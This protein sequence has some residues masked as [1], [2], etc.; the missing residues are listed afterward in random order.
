M[1]PSHSQFSRAVQ[2]LLVKKI[3]YEHAKRRI[4]DQYIERRK[5][6]IERHGKMQHQSLESAAEFANQRAEFWMT[7]V[8]REIEDDIDQV[9]DDFT[10]SVKSDLNDAVQE[11]K[12]EGVR[13]SKKM[14]TG[15]AFDDSPDFLKSFD[16]FKAIDGSESE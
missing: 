5:S 10:N 4:V 7:V 8:L 11:M 6:D 2:N 9:V 1:P 3:S 13:A 16:I 12:I 15:A 14:D